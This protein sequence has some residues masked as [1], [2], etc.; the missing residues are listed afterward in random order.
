MSDDVTGI[1]PLGARGVVRGIVA[2]I[3]GL[4]YAFFVWNAI[5]YLVDMA[6]VGIS[7]YGWAV[8]SLPVVFPMIVFAA[9][10]AIG[11]RRSLGVYVVT[12]LAGL[13]LSAVFWL[14]TVSYA[15]R[16]AESLLS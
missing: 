2:G 14:D 5:F 4:G 8:L 9:A 11:R 12:L 7:G 13:G 15:V 6:E 16:N 10:F 3:G 1:R